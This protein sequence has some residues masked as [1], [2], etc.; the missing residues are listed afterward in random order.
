MNFIETIIHTFNS[1]RS[2]RPTGLVGGEGWLVEGCGWGGGGGR[3]GGGGGGH[4]TL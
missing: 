2:V 1:F 4:E 3:G